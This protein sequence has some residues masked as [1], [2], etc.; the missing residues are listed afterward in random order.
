MQA[1]KSDAGNAQDSYPNCEQHTFKG[2]VVLT[3][4]AYTILRVSEHLI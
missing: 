4:G 3:T 1:F 2:H